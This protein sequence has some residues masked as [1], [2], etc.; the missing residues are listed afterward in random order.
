MGQSRRGNVTPSLT[1]KVAT[2][3]PR[4]TVVV[5]C[6]GQRTEPE[7][8]EALKR[9]PLVRQT[10]S[11]ELRIEAQRNGAVPLTLV[12]DAVKARRRAV[13]NEDD[14]DEFWCVFDVEWP[15]NHPH[16]I[17]ARDLAETHGIRL[18]VSNPCFELWLIL[19]F[20]EQQAWLENEAAV[21]LRRACDQSKGKGLTAAEYMP[22]REIAAD[23]AVAL[24]KMHRRH[25]R[26]FPNDNPSS[27]MHLLMTTVATPADE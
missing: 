25:S 18:A 16:L 6:E 10:A 13:R 24:D 15:S 22:R 23:R 26:T 20:R 27:G 17:E 19:H 9:D 5:F 12:R 8:L 4:K 2:R 21:R 7:Y 14:V 3:R 1:R 11:V